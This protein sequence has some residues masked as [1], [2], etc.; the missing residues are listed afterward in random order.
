MSADERSLLK[1]RLSPRTNKYIPIGLR[2]KPQIIFLL[3]ND[4]LEVLYGGAAGGGKSEGL[5]AA[6]AQYVDVPGYKAILFRRTLRDLALPGA[7]MQRSHE[8]WDN[9]D[10]HWN[11][12]EYK[13][14]FPSGAIIQFGYM[15]H[16]H[17][18]LRYQS[19]EFQFV[20]F[21]ELT[22]FPEHQYLYLF[23]RLRRLADSQIPLRM[24]G[25]TNPGGLGHI[26]VKNRWDLPE[27]PKIPDRVFIPAFI[28]DNPYLDQ[29]SYIRGLEELSELTRDQLLKGDW[30]ARA[31]GGIID[32]SWFKVISP[33]EWF[34]P[35]FKINHCRH[36]D[37]AATEKTE[38]N[39]DPDWTVGVL[40]SQYSKLPEKVDA[41]IREAMS[42]D[43]NLEYPLPP[44]YGIEDVAR[45]RVD[46]GTVWEE[47]RQVA[48][49]DGQAV[50][51]SFEQER[52]ASGKIMIATWRNEL[53]LFTVHR[54]WNQGDKEVR[55]RP[56][57]K[58]AK[59]GR[60]F[61]KEGPYVAPL[62]D[63]YGNFGIKG[64]HDDQV[65]GTSGAFI[66]MQRIEGMQQGR[67]GQH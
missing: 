27:A 6:A 2:I 38:E 35:R 60:I 54:L 30:T 10:A 25:A 13:W 40:M 9:T 24:R 43:R 7:L 14:T 46:A 51:I 28:T 59:E 18:E 36:W 39:P 58:R 33:D 26:W 12:S 63:E 34:D 50:P 66:Q 57:A 19:S 29:E 17:D 23:S 64:V 15:E 56:V 21:D 32:P 41:Q 1:H 16:E 42:L 61:V 65:D 8:W 52:G 55:F 5:L 44:Y 48:H 62:L 22:Q 4:V 45:F 31:T 20:G 49:Q 11:G 47:I 37:M 67:V 53:P 3:L